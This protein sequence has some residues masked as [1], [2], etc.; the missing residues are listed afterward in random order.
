VIGSNILKFT[1]ASAVLALTLAANPAGAEP[2]HAAPARKYED[3]TVIKK[4]RTIDHSRVI[5]T[6]THVPVRRRYREHNHLVIHENEIRHVG[7]V[8]HN[9]TIIEKETRSFRR[10]PV[11][12][13][14]YFVTRYYR[15]VELSDSVVVPVTQRRVFGCHSRWYGRHRSSCG[16]TLRVRG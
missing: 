11:V 12:T 16:A 6:V 15:A 10:V 13:P 14:V 2:R 5:N 1:M 7:V 8:Q 4:S 9:R 3:E